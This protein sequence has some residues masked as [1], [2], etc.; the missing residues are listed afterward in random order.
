MFWI[1]FIIILSPLLGSL[2]LL[3]KPLKS[4]AF[5][6]IVSNG[7]IAISAFLSLYLFILYLTDASIAESHL[8]YTWIEAGRVQFDLGLMV[9]SLSVFMSFVVTSVS[10]LVHIYSIGYMKADESYNRFFI[11]TNF[12]TFSMLLIVFANNF[13][14]L[15]IG[16]E[17]VGLSS[18]I[19]IG[20]WYKKES[21][22]KANFKAFIVN[23]IGDIGLILG[24]S[25]VYIY[26][27]SLDYDNFFNNIDA[28]KNETIYILGF[29]LAVLPLIALL[30]FVGAAA[31][32]A[33]IPLH[34]W[35]PDSMEGPTPISALIHAATMVT[36]GIFMVARLSSLYD[37]SDYVL[38]IILIIGVL[39]SLSMG[40]VALIQN[41]IKRVIAYST[42]SQLGYMTVA[43]GA[44]YY[45]FAIYHLM[46]HAFFKALLFLCA[47]SIILKCHHEQDINKM[48]GLKNIMPVTFITFTIAGLALMGLPLTSGFFSKDLIIDIFKYGDNPLV[49]YSLVAGVFITTLYTTKLYFKVFFGSNKLKI[50]KSITHEHNYVITVPLILLAIPSFFIGMLLFEKI[51]VSGFFSNILSDTYRVQEFYS[52][53]IISLYYYLFHSLTSLSFISLVFALLISYL[54]YIKYPYILDKIHVTF[55]KPIQV[56][57]NEYG[58]IY[59][60][61]KLIPKYINIFSNFL[62]I[63]SD[64]NII[65][66][67][68]VNGMAKLV[69]MLSY[70]IRVIQTGYLY[71]YAFTMIIGLVLFLLLF[72]DFKQ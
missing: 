1:T 41:D 53:N 2:I 17:L 8:L 45:T 9:D 59:I 55:N 72:Y 61:N 10:L 15:F 47:G 31:K 20:F 11:Y 21:A 70:R 13:L 36:A 62:W 69:R 50:E 4:I 51:L 44:S 33:Q 16:W 65:D 6:N 42:I 35:L 68:F 56:L 23:R 64:I 52:N 25:L 29:N 24:V 3:F 19:L 34:F 46:T 63:K 7:S 12:F 32:S 58:F 37:A 57:K 71:H 38:D 30:L 48:G 40:L 26:S 49:Y 67:F 54:I 18:Y 43:L 14:Q 39:T 5:T 60:S 22:V 28:L 27:G 66:N